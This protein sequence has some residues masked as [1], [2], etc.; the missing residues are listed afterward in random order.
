M[1]GLTRTVAIVLAGLLITTG[2]AAISS[3][4][5]PSSAPEEVGL[6]SERLARMNKAIH[7]YVGAGRT[8]PGVV[9]RSSRVTARWCTSG[10]HGKNCTQLIGGDFPIRANFATLLYQSIVGS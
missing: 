4:A 6:S 1:F 9:S 7:E 3:K 8:T 2:S 5:S 10:A